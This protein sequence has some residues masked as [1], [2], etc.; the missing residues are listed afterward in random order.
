MLST[1]LHFASESTTSPNQ[2]PI[3]TSNIGWF[4]QP[5]KHTPDMVCATIYARTSACET[6]VDIRG[7][8]W[9]C[10]KNKF[11]TRLVAM[12]GRR[13]SGRSTDRALWNDD[14]QKAGSCAGFF[15]WLTRSLRSPRFFSPIARVRNSCRPC[16]K[17]T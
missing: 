3:G 8:N 17:S 10:R 2:N 1:G 16:E 15:V 9:P 14:R 7:K 12:A 4:L 11:A 6:K 5:D 13:D